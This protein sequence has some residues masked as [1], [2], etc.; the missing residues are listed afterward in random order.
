M[1]EAAPAP[2][3]VC[4]ASGPSHWQELVVT[5]DPSFAV[6]AGVAEV[7]GGVSR[8]G[9]PGPASLAPQDWPALPTTPLRAWAHPACE[10]GPSWQGGVLSG[11]QHAG[12][13]WT[14]L[15]L[16]TVAVAT[17]AEPLGGIG[18]SCCAAGFFCRGSTGT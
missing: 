14:S 11:W 9:D 3:E 12:Q 13:A 5:G 16:G 7:G 2:A 17:G 15:G 6:A 4:Q 10:D 8:G 1:E 18:D